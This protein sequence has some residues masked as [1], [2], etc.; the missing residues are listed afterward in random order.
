MSDPA[1][2]VQS[3]IDRL[4]EIRAR[5][6]ATYAEEQE[7]QQEISRI[8]VMLTAATKPRTGKSQGAALT[9]DGVGRGTHFDRIL[10]AVRAAGREGVKLATLRDILPYASLAPNMTRLKNRGLIA[11]REGTKLWVAVTPSGSITDPPA[12]GTVP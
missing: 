11:R 8:R 7:V 10:Q 2:A 1:K 12:D 3:L 9:P 6:E 4:A 5:R